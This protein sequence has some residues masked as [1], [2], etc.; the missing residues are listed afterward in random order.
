MQSHA[1]PLIGIICAIILGPFILDYYL[2]R[3]IHRQAIRQR[4][5][6]IS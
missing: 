2:K 4:L 5:R 6:D 1:L 3:F